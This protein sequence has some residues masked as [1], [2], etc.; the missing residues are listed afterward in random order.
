M[1]VVLFSHMIQHEFLKNIAVNERHFQRIQ[2]LL[3]VRS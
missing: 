3:N 1:C 2:V